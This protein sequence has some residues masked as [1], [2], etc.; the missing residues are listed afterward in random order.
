MNTRKLH[1]PSPRTLR[2]WRGLANLAV[3]NIT[4]AADLLDCDEP[5]LAAIEGNLA[6]CYTWL[7]E[8]ITDVHDY[9]VSRLNAIKNGKEK[10]T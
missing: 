1:Q 3:A 9:R 6:A 8:I 10:R 7:F 4:A 2:R 5:E